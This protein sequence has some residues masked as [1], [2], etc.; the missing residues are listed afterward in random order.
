VN[1]SIGYVNDLIYNEGQN[2]PSLPYS[3]II[4]FDDY[5]GVPFFSGDGQ[6]KWVPVLASEY[7]WGEEHMPTYFRKQFPLSFMGF[8]CW[9][10][11]RIDYQRFTRLFFGQPRKRTCFNLCCFFKNISY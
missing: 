7:E 9:E 1:G 11:A 8:I 2:A 6:E 10:E 3:I 5:S 4:S